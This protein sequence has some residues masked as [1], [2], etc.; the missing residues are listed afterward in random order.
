MMELQ[1]IP[2]ECVI[3]PK[4][5]VLMTSVKTDILTFTSY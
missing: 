4:S 3:K 1:I 2:K 5:I